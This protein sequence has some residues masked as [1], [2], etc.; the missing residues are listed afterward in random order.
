MLSATVCANGL[1]AGV[2][3]SGG[4][5]GILRRDVPDVVVTKTDQ[6]REPRG[7]RSVED[8]L[9]VRFPGFYRA[10]ARLGVRA[11]RPGS[12]LRQL[13][14]R[15]QQISAY[16][17]AS[18]RDYESML[19]RY[20]PDLEI[21]FDPEFEALGLSGTYRGHE[22]ILKMIETFQ[23]AWQGL[24]LVPTMFVDLGDRFLGLGR[25]RL[26]GATSGMEFDREFAQIV[27]LKGGLV[28]REWDFLSW[29]KGFE[30]AG[31][32]PDAFGAGG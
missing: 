19:I 17:A 32:D 8:R 24:D 5:A 27:I 15:R 2:R 25:F 30:A 6:S 13:M 20:S 1:P 29:K 22:G 3:A 4:R 18:R 28:V 23:E 7:S 31:L 16:A 26:R 10:L 9:M 21:E 14:L 11:L 12:R